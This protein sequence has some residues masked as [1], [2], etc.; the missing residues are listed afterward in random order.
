MERS[1]PPEEQEVDSS[2]RQGPSAPHVDGMQSLN[3]APSA[4]VLDDDD[5]GLVDAVRQARNAS[6]SDVPDDRRVSEAL[7]EYQR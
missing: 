1:A 4:P 5:E 6:R 2:Q 7:P 3:L